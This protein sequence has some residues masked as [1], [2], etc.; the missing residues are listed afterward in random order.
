M[1]KAYWVNTYRGITNPAAFEA[2]ARL[3]GP[4]IE[5][6]GGRFLVRGNPTKAF[7]SGLMQRVVIVEFDSVEQA[8]QAHETPAYQAALEALNNGAH[9][10]I[11]I[12]EGVA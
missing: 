3:S 6:A 10:D 9:R 2:Y 7:E 12:V 5:A 8:L 4:A 11:R 1:P